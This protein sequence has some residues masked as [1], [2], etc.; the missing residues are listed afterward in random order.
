MAGTVQLSRSVGFWMAG[1]MVASQSINALRV[2]YDPH[3]FARYF[4][5][6]LENVDNIGFVAVYGLRAF[7]LAV[8]ASV[9]MYFK[10]IRTL[11][12]MAL[13]A[14]IMPIGDAYLAHHG[15]APAA[16]VWRHCVIAVFLLLTWFFLRR[17]EAQ[18]HDHGAT[19]YR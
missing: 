2:L 4:G 1:A 9:L 12:L 11:K 8:F 7:F 6:P 17:T 19:R 3:G 10:E 16:I 18:F 5:L 14:V 13:C 15:G